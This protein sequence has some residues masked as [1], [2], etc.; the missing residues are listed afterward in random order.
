MSLPVSWAPYI[1]EGAVQY[2]VPVGVLAS[3]LQVESGGNAQATNFD[4]NGSVDRGPAQINNQAHP[5][6]S[7]AQAYNPSF[8]I[9]W[10][11]KY[12]SGLHAQFGSWNAALQA[13]N[14]GSPTGAPQYAAEVLSGANS[15]GGTSGS[16]AAAGGGTSTGTSTGGISFPSLGA[17]RWILLGLALVLG[18]VALV[19]IL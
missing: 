19:R 7:D 4:S 6:V 18:G 17:A 13:Y 8:A 10:A 12:L 2:Q 3:L 11:A 14:S 15:L 16:A 1:A 9:P 5:G